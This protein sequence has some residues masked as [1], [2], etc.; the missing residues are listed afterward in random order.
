MIEKKAISEKDVLAFNEAC[1]F[2]KVIYDHF[3]MLYEKNPTRLKLLE[4][5]AGHFFFDLQNVFIGF[6]ILEIC[7]ITDPSITK[8]KDGDLDN[9]TI[10]FFCENT[11]F[12]SDLIAKDELE[13]LILEI[14]EFRIKVLPARHKRIAHKDRIHA[15][16]D[17]PLGVAKVYEFEKFISNLE[18]FVNLIN[19]HY[20]NLP[21]ELGSY[22]DAFEV[23][24]ALKESSCFNDLLNRNDIG[25]LCIDTMEASEYKNA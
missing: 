9:L 20:T 16:D 8:R 7:K 21:L 18:K 3:R 14:K 5:R 24:S 10:D 13:A 25:A 15:L 12:S 17:T 23:I 19:M 6:I 2:L 11:D 22:S 1:I 4:D